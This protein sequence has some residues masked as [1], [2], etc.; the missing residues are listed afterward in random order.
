MCVCVCVCVCV[1]VYVCV[2]V[3]TGFMELSGR[4][5]M[6]RRE[7]VEWRGRGEGR[8]GVG[9]RDVYAPHPVPYILEL[10]PPPYTLRP[11]PSISGDGVRELGPVS[12]LHA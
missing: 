11:T 5:V 2:C 9:G 7:G 1:F 4:Q 8:V 10:L 6:R 3:A 12:L